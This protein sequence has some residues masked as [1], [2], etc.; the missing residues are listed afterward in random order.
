MHKIFTAIIGPLTPR[1][2]RTVIIKIKKRTILS[3]EG[4]ILFKVYS[5]PM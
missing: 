4:Y 1:I 3:I 2:I 5:F